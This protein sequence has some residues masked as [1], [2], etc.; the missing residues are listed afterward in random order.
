[1]LRWETKEVYV[2]YV[3]ALMMKLG[4]Q[5]LELWESRS[6][7]E[8]SPAVSQILDLRETMQFSSWLWNT[9]Q[10]LVPCEGAGRGE[11]I[12]TTSPHVFCGSFLDKAKS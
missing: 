8:E 4:H 1:M 11:G 7:A 5:T 6:A 9:G 10:V 3:K 12:C 2:K